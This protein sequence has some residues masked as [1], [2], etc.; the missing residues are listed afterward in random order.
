MLTGLCVLLLN[1]NLL[2]DVS[3]PEPGLQHPELHHHLHAKIQ[4]QLHQE[5]P[6]CLADRTAHGHA[7]QHHQGRR[8]RR[9][10]LVGIKKKKSKNTIYYYRVHAFSK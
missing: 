8:Q 4:E 6:V 1:I 7:G 10:R 9:Q 3:V 5:L 2:I